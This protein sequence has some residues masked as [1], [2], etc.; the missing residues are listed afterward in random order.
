MASA[1]MTNYL[2]LN[3]VELYEVEINLL[4]MNLRNQKTGLRKIELS[5]KLKH[6]N[7]NLDR[8]YI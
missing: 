7:D 1:T 8:L 3:S 4:Q 5:L 6:Q 2:K